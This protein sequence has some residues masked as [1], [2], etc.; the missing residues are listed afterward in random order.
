M[1]ESLIFQY[2]I[3]TV[4]VLIAGYSLFKIIVR[5]FSSKKPKKGEFG[6][7]QECGGH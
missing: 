2:V 5:N 4:I 7:D 3:I 1:E 6:C